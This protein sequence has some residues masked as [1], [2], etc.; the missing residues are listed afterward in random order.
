MRAPLVSI[1]IPTYNR[2]I[3]LRRALESVQAQTYSSIEAV[4]VNDG[5]APVEE[6]VAGFGRARLVNHAENRGLPAAR[7]TGIANAAGAYLGY[8][9]DDD[10]LYPEH[11]RVILDHLIA[12][13]YRWG[14]SNTDSVWSNG[15][16]RLY[17]D[18]EFHSL[19]IRHNNVTPVCCVL[20]ER[21]LIDQVGWFDESLKNHED[22]DLWIRFA[23]IAPAL[24]IRQA[25]C[26][27]DRSRETMISN[28]DEMRAGREL[29]RERYKKGAVMA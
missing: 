24:H 27:I 1:V 18:A 11:V 20:H 9:D 2:P 23:E 28:V 3:L 19:G 13:D 10:W 16:K 25:T 21:S 8:L 29:I 4:V 7:N 12:Y 6:V 22:W 5:G 26:C 14:Y 15:R 17:M